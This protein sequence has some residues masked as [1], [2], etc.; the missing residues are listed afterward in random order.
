MSDFTRINRV[1]GNNLFV[2][3]NAEGAVIICPDK[4]TV[5]LS[6]ADIVKILNFRR[7]FDY[8]MALK[9]IK[10][11]K[12]FRPIVLGYNV[13]NEETG[14]MILVDFTIAT[15]TD[16]PSV[17]FRTVDIAT[18]T[19]EH[20]VS[21][22]Y[23]DFDKILLMFAAAGFDANVYDIKDILMVAKLPNETSADSGAAYC[24]DKKW[25]KL[26]AAEDGF[27]EITGTFKAVPRLLEFTSSAKEG[28]LYNLT[29][30]YISPYNER[31]EPGLYS[32]T[33]A[34]N[35]HTLEDLELVNTKRLPKFEDARENVIYVLSR[36]DGDKAKGSAW[37]KSDED[38]EEFTT[39]I[40]T[41]TS[42]PFIPLAETGVYYIAADVLVKKAADGKYEHIGKVT[43]VNE[44]PDTSS[45]TLK[46]G[47]VYVLTENMSDTKKKGSRWVFDFDT[48]EFIAYTDDLLDSDDEGGTGGGG[49]GFEPG[50]TPQ[51]NPKIKLTV[52]K[53]AADQ[54]L[55]GSSVDLV[56][57]SN[58]DSS[59]MTAGGTLTASM[60]GTYEATVSLKDT[61]NYEW[62]DG[63]TD[64]KTVQWKVTNPSNP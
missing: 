31:F 16:A 7:S 28:V 55:T 59:K 53:Q 49:E 9:N 40:I 24:I 57:D 10:I 36:Q 34:G 62:A 23:A 42:V 12:G 41:D 37:T 5:N 21:I 26:N 11:Q 58:F 8:Q 52:P 18:A 47:V 6:A 1:D 4:G 27:D 33:K 45:V 38:F 19:T 60:A 63:T 3:V 39:E 25:Y 51:P 46:K 20:S 29:T 15:E 14:K 22:D 43:Y 61:T 30:A 48:K 64:T 17:Q 54:E 44:L 56:W 13:E 50:P 2:K 35:K 32:Y